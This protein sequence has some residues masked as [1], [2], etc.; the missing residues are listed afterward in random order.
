MLSQSITHA[1]DTIH[2]FDTSHLENLSVSKAC[3]NKLNKHISEKFNWICDYG[4]KLEVLSIP[5]KFQQCSDRRSEQGLSATWMS[6]ES[7]LRPHIKYP[8]DT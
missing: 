2:A 6:H 5:I 4:R 3:V 8:R 1:F 7:R